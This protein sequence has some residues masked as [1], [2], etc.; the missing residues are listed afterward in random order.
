MEKKRGA[1]VSKVWSS[2]CWSIHPIFIGRKRCREHEN[3]GAP[4]ATAAV[5]FKR[6]IRQPEHDGNAHRT[7][8]TSPLPPH[9]SA[10]A[11]RCGRKL[12]PRNGHRRIDG[13]KTEKLRWEMIR[14]A[15]YL[16]DYTREFKIIV[17]RRRFDSTSASFRLKQMDFF[18]SSIFEIMKNVEYLIE[19][20]SVN[21]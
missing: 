4:C 19:N 13:R 1:R 3:R 10:R 20:L 8:Y 18:L 7:N 21:K 16:S 9:L 15:N 2:I 11:T 5:L 12:A 14:E 17:I 6:F